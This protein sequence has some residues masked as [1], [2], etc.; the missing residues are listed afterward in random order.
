MSKISKEK[1]DQ[2]KS[3]ILATLFENFPKQLFTS[4]ISKLEARDE[5]FIKRL[6][7]ELQEK[8]LV[9]PI[10]KNN[11]GHSFLRRIK[12]QLSSKAYEAYH[13]KVQ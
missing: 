9:N 10:K 7:L 6:L 11:K 12:W 8:G 4:Q 2:I 13:Q 1:I 3:N 5:E